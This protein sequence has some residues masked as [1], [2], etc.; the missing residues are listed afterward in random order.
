VQNICIRL[1]LTVLFTA[2]QALLL[3]FCFSPIIKSLGKIRV[4]RM[5]PHSFY[6]GGFRLFLWIFSLVL[7]LRCLN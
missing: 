5:P 6:V 7:E 3:L 2:S 1:I 4:S